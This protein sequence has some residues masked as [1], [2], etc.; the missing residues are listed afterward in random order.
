MIAKWLTFGG[1]QCLASY[2][3]DPLAIGAMSDGA[4]LSAIRAAIPASTRNSCT[5]SPTASASA[6]I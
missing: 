6:I 4:A 1:A 3:V 2:G 5:V